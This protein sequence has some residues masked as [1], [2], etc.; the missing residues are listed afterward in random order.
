MNGK[1]SIPTTYKGVEMRSKLEAAWAEWFDRHKIKWAYE[2]EGFDLDGLWYLPDF[3][4]P[5]IKTFVEVKGI[6]DDLDKEKLRR[7]IPL[8][9]ERG[10]TVIV[11]YA[12]AGLNYH[13]GYPNWQGEIPDMTADGSEVFAHRVLLH[14]AV[15]VARCCNCGR[16]FF[17]DVEGSWQCQAGCPYSD[18]A[19]IDTFYTEDNQANGGIT[20]DPGIRDDE[21]K[22]DNENDPWDE[23]R[24][25]GKHP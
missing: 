1:F 14:N 6:M 4:L 18:N 19:D 7:L 13:M 9:S 5:E 10:I 16:V 23:E 21:D 3:W 8:A 22:S 12:P 24:C 15:D 17:R 11:G 2:P 25:D 20:L